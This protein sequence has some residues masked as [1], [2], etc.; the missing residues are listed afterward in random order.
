[1]R[2]MRPRRVHR[3]RSSNAAF[4]A[5]TRAIMGFSVGG[6][7]GP[8]LGMT[9]ASRGRYLAV[10]RTLAEWLTII[11]SPVS[12]SFSIKMLG[13]CCHAQLKGIEWWVKDGGGMTSPCGLVPI[14]M[15][16]WKSCIFETV[17]R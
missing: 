13:F 16:I 2:F 12:S 11:L 1:M 9:G 3:G 7:G 6:L 15:L 5:A 17:F 8:R 4:K 10:W 14:D